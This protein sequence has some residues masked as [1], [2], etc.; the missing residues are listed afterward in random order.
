MKD[1]ITGGQLNL[2]FLRFGH[3][4]FS[5]VMNELQIP[6]TGDVSRI[7]FNASRQQCCLRM[8]DGSTVSLTRATLKC[9]YCIINTIVSLK[10]YPV[11]A[12]PAKHKYM[13][14]YKWYK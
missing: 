11:Y 10:K 9:Y 12:Q 3:G 6:E 2:P 1:K 14:N 8:Y 5:F 4:Y 13:F 7:F